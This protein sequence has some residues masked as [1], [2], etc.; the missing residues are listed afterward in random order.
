MENAAIATVVSTTGKAYARNADGELRELHTGDV[1][2]EGE[3]VVTPDGGRVELSFT[4][5]SPLVINDMPEMTLTRDLMDET[6]AGPD[7][8]AAGDEAIDQVLA[9]LASGAD[10]GDA[11]EPTAAGASGGSGGDG[12]SFVRLGR[13]VEETNEFT[14]IVGG[15]GE[16][17]ATFDDNEQQLIDAVDDAAAT[18]EGEAVTIPVEVNDEFNYGEVIIVVS[19]PAN[20][21]AVLNPDNTITY[22]PDPGFSGQDEFTYTATVPDGT[23]ADTA[24]V[25]VDVIPETDPV[26]LPTISIGDDIVVEGD[27]ATVTVSLSQ[28]WTEDVTVSFNTAD[29]TA[30]IVGKDY[31]ANGGTVTI[32]AGDLSTTVSVATSLDKIEEGA[33]NLFVNLSNP[34][35]ATI[36]DGEGEI[37][38][39]D[40]Y[41]PPTTSITDD[42]LPPTI[43]I[44]DVTVSEGDV[45]TLT[46]SLSRAIE[47]DVTFR[48]ES[49]DGSATV[50]GGDYNPATGEVTIAAG[51]T[52]VTISTNTNADN[53]DEPTEQ[54]TVDLSEVTNASV[55]DGTG[56]VTI[57]DDFTPPPVIDDPVFPPDAVDDSYA[58]K[59]NSEVTAN[60][61][62]NDSDQDGGRITVTSNTDPSN[63]TVVVNADGTFTYTPNQDFKGTDSFTYTITDPDGLSDTATANIGI[64]NDPISINFIPEAR[65]IQR[66]FLEASLPGGSDENDGALTAD[67]S[68]NV[69]A[70]D[71]LGSLK[72]NGVEL[73]NEDGSLKDDAEAFDQETGDHLSVNFTSISV[74]LVDNDADSNGIPDDGIYTVN[75]TAALLKVFDN[76]DSSFGEAAAQATFAIDVQD[77]D[78]DSAPTAIRQ[79]TVIDDVPD[80][81]PDSSF[82]AEG[83]EVSGNVVTDPSTGDVSGAD[84]FPV[85][86][87]VVGVVSGSDISNP[88]SGNVGAAIVTALG[89]LTLRAGGGY[90]YKTNANLDIDGD[91]QDIFVYTII[92]D[93][94]DTSTETLT[95]TINDSGFGASPED[96]D[97]DEKGLPF[98]SDP[99]SAVETNGGSLA[100]N[101]VGGTG[102]YTYELVSSADGTYG[103]LTL[104]PDGSYSYTLDTELDHNVPPLNDGIT[105]KDN[106]ESFQVRI[107]DDN[108]NIAI[109]EIQI[110]VIDDVPQ[111]SVR[112][113][114]IVFEGGEG[115]DT[116]DQLPP[117]LAVDESAGVQLPADNGGDRISTTDFSNYFANDE[118]GTGT[119]SVE[120]DVV[121]G[122]DGPGDVNYDLSLVVGGDTLDA[123]SNPIPSGL[124]A[125]DESLGGKGPQIFLSVNGDGEIEGRADGV[126]YFSLSVDADGRATLTQAF[127]DGEENPISIYHEYPSDPNDLA[128]LDGEGD[129]EGGGSL[130]YQ[131]NL[132]Q[133]V[134]DS[135]GDRATEAVDLAAPQG[136]GEQGL[137]FY[138]INFLDDAPSVSVN[139]P[140]ELDDGTADTANGTLEH[141]F[142]ADGA[143]DIAWSDTGAPAGFTYNVNGSGDLEVFQGATKVLTATLDDDGNYVITQNAA[144]VHGN[145]ESVQAFTFGYVV[146]DADADTVSGSLAVNVADV[147]PTVSANEVVLLDDD[148]LGGIADG[149]GDDVDAANASGTLGHTFGV[150]GGEIAYLSTGAP[151]GFTYQASGDDLLIKQGAVTVLTVTLV[152]ETGAYTVTQNAAIVHA[153]AL[154]ENN[155]EFTINYRVTDGDN[156]TQDGTLSINVDDDTPTVS[157]NSGALLDDGPSDTAGG[158]LSHAFGADGPGSI[159]WLTSG[160]PDG[161]SYTVDGDSLSIKQGDTTVVTAILNPTNGQYTVTQIAAIDGV[162]GNQD[163]TLSYSVVDADADPVTGTLSVAVTDGAPAV[164]ENTQVQLDD[165]AVNAN[166]IADGPGDDPDAANTSGTVGHSFGTDGPGGISLLLTG[167]P[168]GFTYVDSGGDLLI[169]QGGADGTTVLT[170]TLNS[171]TGAY[172]VTQNAP[173][174]HADGNAENNEIFTVAYRVADSNNDTQD[175]TL[176]INVD[177]DTPTVSANAAASLDD[178]TADTANGTLEHAFGADGAGDI[179]WS[180]TGAP[181]GFTYSVNGSGDLEVFQGATKVLTATLDDDGNYVITQ[182][183]ALVHG[184]GE[185]A[186]AFTFGYVVTDADADTVSGS[187]AVNVADVSPTVSANEVVLL[188]DDALGGIA[189]GT[190]D[191]VDA[192]N[193]SGT[194]GHTFGVDGGEIA[195]LST[196]APAGFTY[197]ASGDDLLIKQGAVT[198]LTVTLV[199]ET[200]AYTVTQNAAIVHADA[201]DENNQEFTINYRVTDGDNDTQDGTLSINVDDDTPLATDDGLLGTVSENT[202]NYDLG[203]LSLLLDDD[204][205]GADGAAGSGINIAAGDKGGSVDIIGGKLIY[206]NTSQNVAQ[207]ATE[208]ETFIYTIIDGDGDI[209]TAN[210]T[211]NLTDR[212]LSIDSIQDVFADDEDIIGSNGNAGDPDPD[213][214]SDLVIAAPGTDGIGVVTYS[215]ADTPAGVSF[216]ESTDTGLKTLAG[217]VIQ[218]TFDPSKGA[219]GMLIGHTGDVNDPVFTI[220]LTSVSNSQAQYELTLLKPIQHAGTTP[221][222]ED[223]VTFDV[224]VTVTDRDGSF[225]TDRVSVTIDDD[226]PLVGSFNS[227]SVIYNP[228]DP[229]AQG[230]DLL[231]DNDVNALFSAGADG[232]G[233]ISIVGPDTG[234]GSEFEYNQVDNTLYGSIDGLNIFALTVNE[235]GTYAFELLEPRAGRNET[236]DFGGDAQGGTPTTGLK[237]GNWFVTAEPGAD[238]TEVNPS[239]AGL[240]GDGNDFKVGEELR[241]TYQG[242]DETID[243]TNGDPDQLVFGLKA[244]Q[245]ATFTV[246]FYLGAGPAIGTLASV[247]GDEANGLVLDLSTI[248]EFDA[249]V[250]VPTAAPAALKIESISTVDLYAPQD[251]AITFSVAVS[252][253]DGDT[254]AADIQVSVE[255]Q[256]PTESAPAAAPVQ[257]LQ[258]LSEPVQEPVVEDNAPFLATAG[259]DTF[260]FTLAEHGGEGTDV[261][262]SGFGESGVDTLDLRDLLMGEEDSADLGAYLNVTFDGANTVIEVSSMG[263]FNGNPGAAIDQTDQTITLEG[264]DLV[265]VNE[266][267]TVIQNMLDSGQLITD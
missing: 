264:V 194:L 94:G 242:L 41:L 45:A 33:E 155:Q 61:L 165:D 134:I 161:F 4:D 98:G 12:N 119:P 74:D 86:G 89:T 40:D 65:G 179:A 149:T 131:L 238:N 266:L 182:N 138:A 254:I 169:K 108:G 183:A 8:S 99:G 95:I 59:V 251:E 227:L 192:A 226:T 176:S 265:G 43:S 144:L 170:V 14:G 52:E 199:P 209:A 109:T 26:P 85:G 157:S 224:T 257:Q 113:F 55:A 13:I 206:T 220:E 82:V 216:S 208:S 116:F 143:G 245:G 97:V 19:D 252:D 91:A 16:E 174:V 31:N 246:L 152:P 120:D 162:D 236:Q 21:T 135:D 20:G 158:T 3:T 223:D 173:L 57:I 178:G 160:N 18:A 137:S 141:A 118:D 250:L 106:A 88:V 87:A 234:P 197:Q 62:V 72:V 117:F 53:L 127:T 30:T 136:L 122:A 58:V 11:L 112:D 201:L 191:D 262:I 164:T 37:I 187:L 237:F 56:V 47:E 244:P 1:L 171:V 39:S 24:N 67:G 73:L 70:K 133:N 96:I 38:I 140:A 239:R 6:A 203:A 68:F 103:T 64:S 217:A 49:A 32:K 80:A 221:A 231:S 83:A 218:T 100:D 128:S 15:L 240:S 261:T 177:D 123:A 233:S 69:T 124:Y 193:A 34:V 207:D 166:G 181:A 235:D 225:A 27:I 202:S 151:A 241:F 22:T 172:T 211:V 210:F 75:Y 115:G 146:T 205:Y 107:T 229:P 256:I 92:D 71:G 247:T 195:Y 7:A 263:A 243:P 9:A 196:G 101:V 145:G 147:S 222:S 51:T 81:E 230:D 248:G 77:A 185:S 190:G 267:S 110:N 54:F 188:D 121:F 44:N 189:D 168:A 126:L 104:N 260:A 253:G 204:S 23:Q 50:S 167:A 153:D 212:G 249:V 125:V 60:L 232:L 102:P 5:G 42:Y 48:F 36:A 175:G 258:S 10:L 180:D 163:F 28:T 93:D 78:G 255:Q 156:D 186:Q 132:T 111:A 228:L 46:V 114:D 154:D 129:L 198:V 90:T 159:S 29:G 17:S 2:K 130:V 84:G 35:N 215:L 105:I 184:N 25:V 213:D 150:D 66:A 148:A 79:A 219:E 259:D 142:G 200:G 76:A 63:G 214:N 139:G